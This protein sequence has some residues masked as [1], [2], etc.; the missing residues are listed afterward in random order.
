MLR[1]TYEA[2]CDVCGHAEE[3]ESCEIGYG[4]PLPSPKPGRFVGNT[5]VCADCERVAIDAIAE[6]HA[7]MPKPPFR[8]EHENAA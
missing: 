1:V 7:L 6:R 4:M 8:G 2:N 3:R 5:M